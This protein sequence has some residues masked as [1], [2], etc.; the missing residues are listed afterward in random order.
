[1]AA[2]GLKDPTENFLEGKQHPT[3]AVCQRRVPRLPFVFNGRMHEQGAH[4]KVYA[5]KDAGAARRFILA[6][7]PYGLLLR[8]TCC[9]QI[10][11]PQT[12]YRS[13]PTWNLFF[14]SSVPCHFWNGPQ[15][16]RRGS[17]IVIR[18]S[19]RKFLMAPSLSTSD[20]V[21]C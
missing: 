6:N 16:S 21:H 1:M 7:N 14:Y 12:Q 20:P 13:V 8:A 3:T 4:L 19:L 17:T 15:H 18:D 2:L 11:A 9:C 10:I 5:C